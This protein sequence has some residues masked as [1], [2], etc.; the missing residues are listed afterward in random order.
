MIDFS[1]NNIGHFDYRQKE[2]QKILCPWILLNLSGLKDMRVYHPDGSLMGEEKGNHPFFSFGLPGMV[3]KFE[4]GKERDN[5]VIMFNELPIRFS[6]VS[7]G[8]V[9]L[10]DGGDWIQ[11]PLL[12]RVPAEHLPKWESEMRKIRELSL[13]PLPKNRLKVKLTVLTVFD[14]FLSDTLGKVDETPAGK[15]KRL[16]EEDNEFEKSISQ[17]SEKCAYSRDHLRIQF[18]KEYQISPQDYRSQKRLACVMDY[19]SISVLTVDEIAI[20][21]GFQHTSHLCKIFKKHFGKTPGDT[22]KQFRYR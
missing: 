9:E 17:H 21:T 22:I 15:L 1:I 10:E 7:N 12:K 18:Q 6:E 19:I 4:Y 5:W 16:I 2:E 3:N 14:F 11:M 20:E 13:N 8:I